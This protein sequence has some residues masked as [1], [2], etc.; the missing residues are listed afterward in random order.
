MPAAYAEIWGPFS[1]TESNTLPNGNTYAEVEIDDEAHDLTTLCPAASGYQSSALVTVTPNT[2]LLDEGNNFGIQRFGLNFLGNPSDLD[3]KVIQ[4]ESEKT[5]VIKKT[6]N[7]S[8]S[9]FG[10]FVFEGA[11]KGN[12][13]QDPLKLALCYK[14]TDL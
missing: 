11:G 8:M 2:G 9:M 12:T 1:I 4:Q 3:V 6:P 14:K 10:V 13:R 7:S 5:W